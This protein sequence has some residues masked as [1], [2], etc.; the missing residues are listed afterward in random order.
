MNPSI[1]SEFDTFTTYQAT[2]RLWKE[3]MTLLNRLDEKAEAGDKKARRLEDV[4][5][6]RYNRRVF[7]L[8]HAEDHHW[9]AL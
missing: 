4:A 7:K 1:P 9:G 2:S 3:A 8:N 6:A 5:W